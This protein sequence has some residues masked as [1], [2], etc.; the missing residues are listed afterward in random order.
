[1]LGS[2]VYRYFMKRIW[3]AYPL[4]LLA[5]TPGLRGIFN[6]GYRA[7]ARN[8]FRFSTLC[9]L[10]QRKQTSFKNPW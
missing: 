10:A 4:Y 9:G 6:Q 3:W 8:R 7:F 2:D 5:C 1:M